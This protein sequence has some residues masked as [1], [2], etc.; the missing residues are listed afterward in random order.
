[1]V[2]QELEFEIT[3]ERHVVQAWTA[4]ESPILQLAQCYRLLVRCAVVHRRVVS[5][6]NL[7]HVGW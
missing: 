3:S 5:S 4:V 1:M 2:A 7:V 6:G